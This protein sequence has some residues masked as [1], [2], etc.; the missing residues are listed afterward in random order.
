MSKN[1]RQLIIDS[2]NLVEKQEV[3]SSNN[4]IVEIK[5][6]DVNFNR[7]SK[8]FE[9]VKN[10]NLNIYENDILG[11]VGESGSGKTTLGRSILGLWDHASGEVRINGK[12]VPRKRIKSVNKNNI[13]VYKAGQMIFQDPTSSLDGQHKVLDI[14]NEGLKNFKFIETEAQKYIDDY[15]EQINI[16]ENE[17]TKITDP[18]YA[19]DIHEKDVFN[20]KI[21][22]LIKTSKNKKFIK[23]VNDFNDFNDSKEEIIE[24]D[25]KMKSLSNEIHDKLKNI[26]LKIKSDKYFLK[27]DS[28]NDKTFL[29]T[30]EKDQ[31]LELKKMMEKYEDDSKKI[32]QSINKRISSFMK[33]IVSKA[34]SLPKSISEKININFSLSEKKIIEKINILEKWF[35]SNEKKASEI[36]LNVIKNIIIGLKI[37]LKKIEDKISGINTR[38]FDS[39]YKFLDNKLQERINYYLELIKD[40]DIKNNLKKE[41]IINLNNEYEI[42]YQKLSIEYLDQYRELLISIVDENRIMR[43][44]YKEKSLEFYNDKSNLFFKYMN[45][46]NKKFNLLQLSLITWKGNFKLDYEKRRNKKLIIDL[47]DRLELNNN[48]I[49]YINE[50]YPDDLS[51]ELRKIFKKEIE[52]INKSIKIDIKKFSIKNPD[53]KIEKINDEINNIKVLI[54]EKKIVLD[55]K[56]KRKK[57]AIEKIKQTLEL[58]GLTEDAI[59]KYPSQF[60][61]GQ[62]QRIGIARTIITKPKF[63]I[64]DEP[65]SALD[66][67]VQAQVINLLKDLHDEMGLTMV[68]IAHDL[69][70]VHYISNKLAVIY[71]GN[72]VEYGE[73]DKVYKSPIHP[74]TKSL[75]NAMPS[76]KVIG[77]KLEVS[78]YKWSDHKYNE[79][80]GEKLRKINEE[81]F[82]FGTEKEIKAW[83]K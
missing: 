24:F 23:L 27:E 51:T 14:V 76:L 58:V 20:K 3:F 8:L 32:E 57:V 82:V 83:T 40:L 18:K 47:N 26:K 29:T 65:I 13:W 5:G 4:P 21:I 62:K 74:Y 35:E 38:S 55:S 12:Q 60:S 11:I 81:H 36:N 64:A 25:E 68:F 34:D 53:K 61:G 22:E 30:V 72:I 44:N 56:K 42:E 9:A 16:L 80:S 49:S 46:M 41:K 73:S 28:Q 19:K 15:N 43:L 79:F 54:E 6:L 75:I 45:N 70:M 71:R 39:L 77:K 7:S 10:A 67:S 78:D 59:N 48:K 63:I 31:K 66:V 2:L 33:F 69:Q 37:I 52:E 50:N 1:K 17:I